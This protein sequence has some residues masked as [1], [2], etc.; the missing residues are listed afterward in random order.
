MTLGELKEAL[1]GIST[2]FYQEKI[3][4]G[5]EQ[6][7]PVLAMVLQ[8]PEF[9]ECV[10]PLMEAVQNKDYVLVADIFY[11]EMAMRIQ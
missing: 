11:Y 6:L 5:L 2:C 10:S 4:E 3:K 1:I 8:V 7:E 9:G